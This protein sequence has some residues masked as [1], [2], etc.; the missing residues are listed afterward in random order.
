MGIFTHWGV[1]AS[2]IVAKASISAEFEWEPKSLDEA[3]LRRI[4]L[5]VETLM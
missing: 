1:P 5:G 3:A 2:R 4:E